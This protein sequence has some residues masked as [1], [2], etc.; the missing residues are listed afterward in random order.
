MALGG[1]AA[2]SR[3]WA[4]AE[5]E[6]AAK[7]LTKATPTFAAQFKLLLTIPG[8][9]ALLGAIGPL[10]AIR[11]VVFDLLRFEDANAAVAKVA[12]NTP[13]RGCWGAMAGLNPSQH[14]SGTSVERKSHLSK[15]GHADIRKALY[16][17][18]LTALTHNPFVRDLAARLT[19][20]SKHPKVAFR[21]AMVIVGAAMRKLLR[22]AYGVLKSNLPFD[23]NFSPQPSPQPSQAY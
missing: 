10:T 6:V 13:L 18:A 3:G 17:P 7:T 8:K 22:L 12:L 15:Q 2:R 20:K 4:I 21:E 16:M 11:L 19:A 9:V 14:R 23:P 5:L 1:P